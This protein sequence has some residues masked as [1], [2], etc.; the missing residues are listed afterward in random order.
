VRCAQWRGLSTPANVWRWSSTSSCMVLERCWSGAGAVLER[1][2]RACLQWLQ[3]RGSFHH[4]ATSLTT[5]T[6]ARMRLTLATL[7]SKRACDRPYLPTLYNRRL[8]VPSV[9]SCLCLCAAASV[10]LFARMHALRW[11][12][13]SVPC[14][15]SASC[16]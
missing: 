7:A 11:A 12:R 1:R 13:P 8:T 14:V 4:D 6:T 2:C 16:A 10:L 9:P 3:W 5:A 15:F